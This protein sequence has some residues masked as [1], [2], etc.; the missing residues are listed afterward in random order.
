MK[1]RRISFRLRLT[2]YSLLLVA[3]S[4]GLA[5]QLSYYFS[6]QSLQ[7]HL[8]AELL[9][10]VNTLAPQI[11][12]DL[13]PMIQSNGGQLR[14]QEEFDLIR[15]VL[16][17]A[18]A[19][20][21]M[22][23]HGSPLYVMRPAADFPQS[24]ELEFVVM[25]DRDQLGNFFVGNSYRSEPYHHRVLAGQ[26]EPTGVY[27]DSEGVWISAAAPLRNSKG[28][29]VGIL[30]ADRPVNFFYDEARKQTLWIVASALACLGL[31]TPLAAWLARSFSRP[32]LELNNA[33]QQI[34]NGQLQ[35]RV[36]LGRNDE[37]GD[38]GDSINR[39]AGELEASQ[40]AA[41]EHELD[42]SLAKEMAESANHAKS[43]FLS[44]MSH[45]LR[46]PLNSILGFSKL[47]LGSDLTPEQRTQLESVEESA[48]SLFLLIQNIL[49]FSEVERGL[50]Q[51]QAQDFAPVT[52]LEKCQFLFQKRAHDKSLHFLVELDPALP[53]LLRGDAEHMQQILLLLLDNA[54]KFTKSG[55]VRLSAQVRN[56]C[57]EASIEDTGIGM[58]AE[59]REELFQPFMQADGSSARLHDGSGLG[60]AIA[61]R[62][63]TL[64]G[65]SIGAE[66]EVG[67]GSRFWFRVPVE[68]I[69]SAPTPPPVLAKPESRNQI[70]VLVVEDNLTNQKLLKALLKKFGHEPHLAQ[71]GLEA[72]AAAQNENFDLILMDCAMPHMDGYDATRAIRTLQAPSDFRSRIVAVT[73][74]ALPGDREKC[75]L[76]GMDGFVSK[77]VDPQILRQVL[78][79]AAQTL[80]VA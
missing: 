47:L 49:G 24:G 53:R 54:F 29:V 2:A 56:S 6:K 18:K 7:S 32:V 17:K 51:I 45:E 11:D 43:E 39:M 68:V 31:V 44:R 52:I 22:T 58:S 16:S 37:L 30:Q 60:L 36:A 38:L 71:D 21:S 8:G 76:A 3:I 61:H 10:V 67:R 35:H 12:A 20:N 78:E 69:E 50:I 73:S 28:V 33:T 55:S 19:A 26:A 80:S 75:I 74:N 14:G 1:S 25:T 64:M 42:L 4:I 72:V 77:P 66:S 63:I 57:F 27:S 41:L 62:L 9:A 59:T 15:D 46:T 13:L 5:A 34:A 79:E 65:G 40:T 48:N 70:R 23:S